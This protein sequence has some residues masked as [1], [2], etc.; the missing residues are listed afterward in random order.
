MSRKHRLPLPKILQRPMSPA[1]IR[2]GGGEKRR[3][4]LIAHY[5]LEKYADAAFGANSDAQAKERAEPQFFEALAFCLLRDYIPAFSRE[6]PGRRPVRVEQPSRDWIAAGGS[7]DSYHPGNMAPFYQAQFVTAIEG[8]KQERSRSREWV[9]RWLANAEEVAS[10][11]VAAKRRDLLPARY[12]GRTTAQAL[13]E[14]FATIPREVR[15]APQRFLPGGDGCMPGYWQSRLHAR[16]VV[17]A[18]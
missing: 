18:Q 15:K 17:E 1:A 13:R 10:P 5:K 12:R 16:R 7:H 9:F 3:A 8:L 4:A 11:K 14:A 6:R 2:N